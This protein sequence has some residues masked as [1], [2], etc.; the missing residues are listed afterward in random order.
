MAQAKSGPARWTFCVFAAVLAACLPPLTT[1]A[2]DTCTFIGLVDN[3]WRP[4]IASGFSGPK[5]VLL[6]FCSD[7]GNWDCAHLPNDGD[8]VVIDQ[9][10]GVVLDEQRHISL[11]TL[12]LVDDGT[13]FSQ[14][15]VRGH[16]WNFAVDEL[17]IADSAIGEFKSNTLH[18]GRK[19]QIYSQTGAAIPQMRV[20]RGNVTFGSGQS[21]SPPDPERASRRLEPATECRLAVCSTRPVL[22]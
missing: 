13:V 1:A 18:I 2:S 5:P 22:P 16:Q 3:S 14:G 15:L 19:L 20:A 4:V 21:V 8:D 9:G 12:L 10:F 11:A 6:L 17:T 7:A